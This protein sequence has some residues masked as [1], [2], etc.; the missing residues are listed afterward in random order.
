MREN[1]NDSY[2]VTN[3][4][5]LAVAAVGLALN[6]AAPDLQPEVVQRLCG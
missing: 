1:G 5:I 4:A 2:T 6:L 3:P